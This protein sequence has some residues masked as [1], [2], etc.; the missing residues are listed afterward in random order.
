MDGAAAEV[1]QTLRR[2][3]AECAILVAL[4]AMMGVLGP[5]GTGEASA[6]RC[7]S[8]WLAAIVG[9]GVI[10][11]M[12]D[13]AMRVP[14]LPLALRI[15]L[16]SLMMTPPV[17]LLVTWLN[18][19]V[20]RHPIGRSALGELAWRVLVV[21]LLVMT[22]RALVWRRPPIVVETR[23]VI[24][25]PVPEAEAIF[26]QR[27][28]ARIRSAPLIAVEAH[29]HYLKVHTDTG[30]EM[31]TARFADA[32]DELA[33]AYGFRTHRSWWVAGDRIHAVRWSRGSGTAQL[34]GGIVAPVSRTQAAG[35]REAG[36]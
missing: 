3:A 18:A 28:P 20:M 22:V 8:Y 27:L 17:M 25:P 13:Q 7:Y 36:W 6:L 14:R 33:D 11:I 19:T 12:I 10:G 23:K 2:I 9:G 4:G 35:L 34:A 1:P 16:T 31:I 32:L 24:A 30:S 29:D 15:L 5:Y 26:R 21:S